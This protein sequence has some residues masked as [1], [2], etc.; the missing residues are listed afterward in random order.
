MIEVIT[1]GG[2]ITTM[3][4]IIEYT[5]NNIIQ[6]MIDYNILQLCIDGFCYVRVW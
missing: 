3:N 1:S 5:C 4:I 6:C 2:T